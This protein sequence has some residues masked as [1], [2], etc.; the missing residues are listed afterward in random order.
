MRRW[1][2]I[3]TGSRERDYLEVIEWCNKHNVTTV[4]IS[5]SDEADKYS[6]GKVIKNR[7][8]N[9][10]KWWNLGLDY[11]ADKEFDN[12]EQYAVAILNDDVILPDVWYDVMEYALNTG[13]S[14]A[15]GQRFGTKELISGYAFVLQGRH[16]MRID[17]N[18]VWWWG[19]TD[20]EMQCRQESGFK[21]MHNLDVGN[22]YANSE[23]SR[24][25]EQ[26][27]KDRVY[28][29]DKWKL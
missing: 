9:I 13:V 19:D 3:P 6:V 4:T 27:E 1:A 23:V 28:F 16:D 12:Q 14:G 10:S 24:F 25:S 18:L 15:S 29:N 26:I 17:E 22:K 5:T 2:V 7:E 21:I 20:I 11:I 8:L